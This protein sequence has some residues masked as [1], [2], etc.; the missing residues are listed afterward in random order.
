MSEL[1][2]V[3]LDMDQLRIEQREGRA[4]QDFQEAPIAF[5]PTYQVLR[6]HVLN[7][8]SVLH[9]ATA[10]HAHRCCSALS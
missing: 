7:F 6:I 2:S 8:Y 1:N 5:K 3:L 4:F 9:D 10:G